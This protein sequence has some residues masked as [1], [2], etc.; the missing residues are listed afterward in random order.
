METGERE[1]ERKQALRFLRPIIM[2]LQVAIVRFTCDKWNVLNAKTIRKE[3]NTTYSFT[4]HI[5]VY[6][7]KKKK[8]PIKSSIFH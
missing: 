1:R 8:F 6:M 4:T 3:L 7:C 5:Y 2:L